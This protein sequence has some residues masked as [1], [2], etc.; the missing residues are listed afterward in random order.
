M[1]LYAVTLKAVTLVT[2][3]AG[4]NINPGFGFQRRN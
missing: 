3:N 2:L 1:Y 4:S